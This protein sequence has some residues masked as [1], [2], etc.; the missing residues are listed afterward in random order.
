MACSLAFGKK[1]VIDKHFQINYD[2]V[3][4]HLYFVLDESSKNTSK[5]FSEE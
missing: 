3:S 4:F 1:K 2:V 5:E